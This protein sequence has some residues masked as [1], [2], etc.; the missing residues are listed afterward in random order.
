MLKL[1]KLGGIWCPNQGFIC[2]SVGIDLPK[3]KLLTSKGLGCQPKC[4]LYLPK[5][6]T[7]QL[8]RPKQTNL[9]LKWGI[10]VL[11]LGIKF[12][13]AGTLS[14]Q[15]QDHHAQ[16][17]DSHAQV[18]VSRATDCN[19]GASFFASSDFLPI[20]KIIYTYPFTYPLSVYLCGL[21]TA[22]LFLGY[23]GLD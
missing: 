12:I 23:W 14:A 8:L 5:P 10:H 17:E 16:A 11:N 4:G 9:I 1:Q 22:H 6:F 3:L 7:Y 20:K 13:Q 19:T 2:P 15:T 21:H 18:G